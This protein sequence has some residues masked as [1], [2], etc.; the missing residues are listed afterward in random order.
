[1]NEYKNI[2]ITGGCGFIGS[3]FINYIFNTTKFNIINI[4]KFNYCSDENNILKNIRKSPRYKLYKI[5]IANQNLM[6]KILNVH[7]IDLIIH[8]AAQTHVS[9]PAPAQADP[10]VDGVPRV[11]FQEEDVGRKAPKSLVNR[12]KNLFRLHT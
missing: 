4:D 6:L 8:F 2:L 5:D 1:M 11:S 12:C 3:N 9:N 7:N 10:C